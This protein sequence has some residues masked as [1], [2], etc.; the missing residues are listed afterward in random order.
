MG[1]IHAHYEGVLRIMMQRKC[2]LAKAME[3]YGVA[4]N[5]LKGFISICELKIV[6]Q[7]KF[8]AVVSTE[9]ESVVESCQS[10]TSSCV[11]GWPCQTTKHSPNSSRKKADFCL[12]FLQKVFTPEND[13][14]LSR[15][16]IAE[17]KL[18]N[19]QEMTPT[20]NTDTHTYI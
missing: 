5:T 1:G 11:A 4:R 9:R 10:K 8:N 14:E 19:C 18:K 20:P 2:S 3:K 16:L 13:T 6:D 12:S 17:E 15:C 7:D